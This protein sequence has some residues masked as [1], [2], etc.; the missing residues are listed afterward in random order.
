MSSRVVGF[1][2]ELKKSWLD[3][4]A[5]LVLAG[6]TDKELK[7]ELDSS[8]EGELSDNG[9]VRG[10]KGKTITVLMKLWG[11]VPANAQAL[12]DEAIKIMALSPADSLLLHWG[13]AMAVYPYFYDAVENV[14]R[15]ASLQ[16]SFSVSQLQRRMREKYGERETVSRAVNRLVQSLLEWGVIEELAEKRTFKTV[17]AVTVLDANISAW[18]LEASLIASGNKSGPVDGLIKSQALFPCKFN[19][20]NTTIFSQH[21]RLQLFRQGVDED[22][23]MF[24]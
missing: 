18:V 8:L 24:K 15:L 7:A 6:V 3:L 1:D 17:Q 11:K 5:R 13:L 22:V 19:M 16:G 9:C 14:G 21:P 2:R 10:A 4:T 20:L 12:R 23:V